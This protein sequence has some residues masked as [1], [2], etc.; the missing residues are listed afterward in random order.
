V[1]GITATP[2]RGDGEG[3]GQVFQRLVYRKAI[4]DLITARY[5]AGVRAVQVS[6]EAD[7]GDL[8]L[9]LAGDFAEGDLE[10]VLLDA[11]APTHAVAAFL[12]HGADR[13]RA[14]LFAPTVRV[15]HAMAEA[16]RAA[17]VPAEA[18]DGNTPERERAAILGRLR[19][20]TTRLL[21]NINVLT[22]GYD[23]PAIDT[24]IVARPTRSR[25]L[26]LQAVGR[27]LR[28]Y[29]GKRDCLII[30][31]VGAS[32]RHDLVT[33]PEALGLAAGG[34]SSLP[35]ALQ[36]PRDRR[37]VRDDEAPSSGRLVSQAVDPFQGRPIHWVRVDD[38]GGR[39]SFV[40]S[41]PDGWLRL[42]P[43]DGRS[44]DPADPASRWDVLRQ[45]RRAAPE[46]VA[47]GLAIGY[48]QGIAEDLLRQ[49]GVASVLFDPAAPGRARPATDKQRAVLERLRV[50]IPDGLTAGEASDLI[51]A[52]FARR[53]RPVGARP[54]A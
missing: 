25:V 39:A 44:T 45:R 13:R 50:E 49:A 4:A 9:N 16:F 46:L 23:E 36:Q 48:A 54:V 43:A 17:G 24:I 52:A 6:I 30:D 33:A 8:P 53:K 12:Q 41:L 7:F 11:Q 26:Y 47:A 31:L 1:V 34:H 2:E 3:L 18:L 32:T 28:P 5:L 10:R 42:E 14:L 15:A 27:G 19:A 40:L 20:G 37:A 22:E 35:G 38:E 51:S 29:P 21:S